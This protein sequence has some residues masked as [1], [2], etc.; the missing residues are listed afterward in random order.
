MVGLAESDPPDVPRH[1]VPASSPVT[2]PAIQPTKREQR[3][4]KE[5]EVAANEKLEAFLEGRQIE[6]DLGK[7]REQIKHH[8]K[9]IE[10]LKNDPTPAASHTD[11]IEREGLIRQHR[12]HI[13]RLEANI[14]RLEA[15]EG[16]SKIRK[17]RAEE[18]YKQT[19]AR[20]KESP[21]VDLLT[22]PLGPARQLG[23]GLLR[24][25]LDRGAKSAPGIG[26]GYTYMT[27]DGSVE[28]KTL[29][30][31]AGEIGVGPVDVQTAGEGLAF[32]AH[33]TVEH[34]YSPLLMLYPPAYGVY[35]AY[36]Y[37]TME[38]VQ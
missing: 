24:K 10:L 5:I 21:L 25:V 19:A 29:N 14:K 22:R 23:Q 27:T 34:P 8:E 11:A 16:A 32:T 13:G 28:W 26:A 20:L 35:W 7:A 38:E 9:Q 17:Q 30:A 4:Y 2:V 1:D 33:L 36:H 18:T 31:V 12:E 15:A 6:T 3:I 37:L